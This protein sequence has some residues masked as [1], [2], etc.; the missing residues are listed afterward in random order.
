V[1]RPGEG[2]LRKGISSWRTLWLNST[3]SG[4]AGVEVEQPGFGL[5]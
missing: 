2:E 5:V 1:H 3:K 4:V